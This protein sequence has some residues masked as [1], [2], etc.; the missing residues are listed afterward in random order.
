MISKASLSR[1]VP[2]AFRSRYI[3][4]SQMIDDFAKAI[5]DLSRDSKLRKEIGRTAKQKI[6]SHYTWENR[7]KR[8]L[9]IYEKVFE[10][11]KI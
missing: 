8:M 9:D 11:N 5:V 10:V 2:H 4:R 1:G 7:K 6:Q 3:N